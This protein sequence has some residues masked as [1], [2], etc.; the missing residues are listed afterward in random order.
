MHNQR[1]DS[2]ISRPFSNVALD[3]SISNINSIAPT[4]PWIELKK[5]HYDHKNKHVK[6]KQIQTHINIVT[7]KTEFELYPHRTSR[8]NRVSQP[9]EDTANPW[10]SNY[11][12]HQFFKRVES[13]KGKR[14]RLKPSNKTI[15]F[16][17]FSSKKKSLGLI[18]KY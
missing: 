6:K 14:L 9:R 5:M 16:K 13:P 3:T 1:I 15:S 11:N 17:S 10:E 18:A 7:I 8:L 4:N 12:N 2:A